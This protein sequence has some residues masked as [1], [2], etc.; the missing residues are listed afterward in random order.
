MPDNYIVLILVSM[1][2]EQSSLITVR[3]VFQAVL[4]H[5]VP[6]DHRVQILVLMKG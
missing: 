5:V 6:D 3:F 1:Q 4:D 2:D